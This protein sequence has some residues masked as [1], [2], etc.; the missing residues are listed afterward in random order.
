[1]LIS[2][3]FKFLLLYLALILISSCEFIEMEPLRIKSYSPS[4]SRLDNF[5]N[6]S[7]TINFSKSTKISSVE[8]SFSLTDKGV[9]ISGNFLWS[10]DN[11]RMTF[12]P[13]IELDVRKSYKISLKT[14]AEDING[15]SLEDNFIKYIYVTKDE[16]R[17]YI[18]NVSIANVI[19]APYEPIVIQ[20]SEPV[21]PENWL[22]N[23]SIEPSIN[24]TYSWNSS[25]TVFTFTPIEKYNW[26]EEYTF[27]I[28]DQLSDYYHNTLSSEWIHTSIR[29]EEDTPV[30]I[31]AL[32]NS[33]LTDTYTK[34][35]PSDS[36]ITY[37]NTIKTDESFKIEF[38]RDITVSSI[39]SYLTFDPPVSF[40]IEEIKEKYKSIITI[41]PREKFSYNNIHTL[42]IKKGIQDE[43]NNQLQESEIYHLK[44]NSPDSKPPEL[45]I[46]QIYYN[47]SSATLKRLDPYDNFVMD[48]EVENQDYYIFMD[49]HFLVP[50]RDQI[51]TDKQKF[52]NSLL[53]NFS[54]N[55]SNSC[56]DIT[57]LGAYI[58]PPSGIS[59]SEY[60][61]TMNHLITTTANSIVVRVYFCY[62]SKPPRG[63]INLSLDKGFSDGFNTMSE[64]I[65]ITY[66]KGF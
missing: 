15:N 53:D 29:E 62:V 1:M 20:F 11:K 24:G 28:S 35:D 26:N 34:D 49:L 59:S 65:S 10:N 56:A 8:R 31:I 2:R 57:V 39:K 47:D 52:I 44:F 21:P 66:N 6:F 36:V 14:T 40:D 38:N 5:D 50:H 58:D 18:E 30:T 4:Q 23:F 32:R 7:I 63:V 13:V 3:L 60:N 16:V 46:S 33:D 45:D 22:A 42:T 12:T 17:P 61:D 64:S 9:K 41:K 43:F 48:S 55:P 37:N 25:Q 51:L 19:T 27:K 54:L